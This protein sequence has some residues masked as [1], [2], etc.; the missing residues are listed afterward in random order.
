MGFPHR[1]KPTVRKA[2]TAATRCLGTVDSLWTQAGRAPATLLVPTPQIVSR[3]ETANIVIAEVLLGIGLP[4]LDELIRSCRFRTAARVT[5]S[6]KGVPRPTSAQGIEPCLTSPTS[7]N[8]QDIKN[9]THAP[10]PQLLLVFS[11][12]EFLFVPGSLFSGPFP[13][14]LVPFVKHRIK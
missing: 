6:R 14:R 13:R 3:V 8:P 11:S 4:L 9:G 5:A 10:S 12:L 1:Q 2:L 7:L